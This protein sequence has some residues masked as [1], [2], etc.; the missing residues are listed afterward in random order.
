MAHKTDEYEIAVL[1]LVKYMFLWIVIKMRYWLPQNERQ[2]DPSLVE[3]GR[4]AGRKLILTTEREARA[5]QLIFLF[6]FLKA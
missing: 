5:H 1:R 6:C 4:T 2:A 3:Y